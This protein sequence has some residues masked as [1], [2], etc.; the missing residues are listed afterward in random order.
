MDLGSDFPDL[1]SKLCFVKV[2]EL[3]GQVNA[4]VILRISCETILLCSGSPKGK[5][6]AMEALQPVVLD[7]ARSAGIEDLHAAVFPATASRFRKRLKQLGWTQ[8]KACE[9]WSRRTS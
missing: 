3:D 9:L 7:A 4:A 6:A 1:T 5:M 2:S 8:D